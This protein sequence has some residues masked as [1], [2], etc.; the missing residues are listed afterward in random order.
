MTCHSAWPTLGHLAPQVVHRDFA[1]AAVDLVVHVAVAIA[2]EVQDRFADRLRG[3]RAGVER[4]A[5]QQLALRAR[6]PPRARFCFAAAMA[7]FWPAGPLPITIKSYFIG[8]VLRMLAENELGARRF[9]PPRKVG[10]GGGRGT[11]NR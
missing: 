4:D 1:L 3:D 8:D 5:A 7:A 10:D 6:R 11:T 9:A 2:G